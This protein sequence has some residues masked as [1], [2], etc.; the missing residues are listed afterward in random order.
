[1]KYLVIFAIIEWALVVKLSVKLFVGL[2]YCWKLLA[3]N[4]VETSHSLDVLTASV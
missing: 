2:L 3:D 4:R 1:M